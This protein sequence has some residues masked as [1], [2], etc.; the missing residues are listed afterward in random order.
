MTRDMIDK[1]KKLVDEYNGLQ[2]QLMSP[3]TAQNPSELK[4]IGQR[5]SQ[6]ESAKGL[7]EEY[8]EI[9]SALRDSQ[10]ILKTET[11]PEMKKFAQDE[12]E[13]AEAKMPTLMEKVRLELIPKDPNDARNCIVEIRAGVGGEEAA[14]FAAE[15]GRMYIR[16]AESHRYSVELMSQSEA[17]A[18]G[19]K[20]MIFKITGQGVYG[21]MKYESGVH[22]VQRIPSTEAQGR[23]H[24]ST[25]SIAVLPE[26]EEVDLEVRDQDLRIDV[27]R[28]GGSGGQSVNTT[29]SAV[30]ITHMPTGIVV[31]CQDERSQ[32]KNRHKAMSILR[33]RL[34]AFEAEKRQKELGDTRLAQIGT[35]DRSDKIRTY[36][37]PQ[38]RVTDHR[39][40]VSWS[41]IPGIMMGEIDHIMDAMTATDQ[42]QILASGDD[43]DD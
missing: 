42:A 24:T 21:K 33:A 16:W 26:V 28:S 39:I 5:L 13:Q 23:I 30:R 31:A 3:G 41:N 34:F 29:D 36:N 40:K 4:R 6:L 14:L 9:D 10:E 19:M 15:L 17:S 37:F 11:D 32:L 1:L 20:E 8:L 22:R 43:D 12:L 2:E 27:Y 35:G 38:D 7:Y 18:G 25:A